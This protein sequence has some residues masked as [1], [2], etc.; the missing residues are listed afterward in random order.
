MRMVFFSADKAEVQRLSGELQEAGIA[1]EVR[2]E[3]V[4]DGASVHLPEAELWV[5]NDN[6]SHRAFL[7]CVQ[8]NA[9]FARRQTQALSSDHW[10]EGLAA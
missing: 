5:K 3:V 8:R 6:D 2:K 9:G 10:H 7:L 1:C 4:V